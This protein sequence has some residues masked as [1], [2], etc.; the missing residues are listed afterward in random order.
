MGLD[1]YHLKITEKYDTILDYFRLSELAACP[2]MISRHEHLI[3][4]IEEPAGYFDVFIFKD[5]QELQLYA[6]KNPATSDRALITGGP[7]HLRQELKKLEDRYNLNPSD[8]FSEQHTHTYSSFLKKTEITYTRRFYSMHDV[9]RKV[10]Y[11]T[12]AGYQRRGMNQD[13]FKIFTNDTLYFRKEDVI[14]AMDY[15]YDDDPADY[16]ERIDNFRQNFIDNFIEGESIFFI[17]W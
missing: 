8:F 5:E 11:H 13:F 2:E 16:K 17:S 12:D 14:R 10:L 1:I 7:D 3:A 4:E 15:I 9:K 6:K